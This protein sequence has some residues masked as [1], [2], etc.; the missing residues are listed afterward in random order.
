MNSTGFSPSF[1]ILCSFKT[2]IKTSLLIQKD[3]KKL[4]AFEM[5]CCKRMKN[6]S[7]TEKKIN[8]EVSADGERG[9]TGY[10]N[11]G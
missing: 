7:W 2:T 4:A 11:Y 3:R 9:R 5:W 1:F 10:E 8:E 6:V